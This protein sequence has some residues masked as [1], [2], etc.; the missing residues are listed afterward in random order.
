[1]F[2]FLHNFH[3][4]NI[5]ISI[6]PVNVYWYGLFIVLGMILGIFISI[7]LAERYSLSKD[8]LID[9]LFWMIIGGVIGARIYDVF[10]EFDFYKDH[11]ANIFMI[12]QGG[13]A[14]HGAILGS[15]LILIYYC[16]KTGNDFWKL[17]SILVPGAALGQAI[18]RW[19]NYF[20]QELYGLPTS[21]PWGIPIDPI[22]RPLD[23]FSNAYFQPTFLYESLGNLMI[24]AVLYIMHLK[25][26]KKGNTNFK[27]ITA[28]YLVMY[29]VLRFTLEFIRIDFTPAF[30]GL[31][32]PQF[33]SLLAIVAS[34]FILYKERYSIKRIRSKQV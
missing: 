1:M 6:G 20:N 14:I 16:K 22:N 12:W 8:D 21:L 11:L 15:A 3:P 2:N 17:S 24:F 27:L 31:R 29:S 28:A 7:K 4:Q 32:F 23:Y 34:I 13:L 18:G 25:M 19:G 30:L 10:L 26:A 5:L 33:I 9:L